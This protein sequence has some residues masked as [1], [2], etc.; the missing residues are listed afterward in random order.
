[1]CIM[2]FPKSGVGVE[3]I[4]PGTVLINQT[5]TLIQKQVGLFLVF[6]KIGYVKTGIYFFARY[7]IR[8]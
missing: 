7:E 8:I 4:R 2:L 3:F 6:T 1:M 5:P